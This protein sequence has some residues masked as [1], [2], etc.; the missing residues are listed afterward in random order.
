MQI[1]TT[2]QSAHTTQSHR[3][4]QQSICGTVGIVDGDPDG[5]RSESIPVP[6][7]MTPSEAQILLR[8]W[9]REIAECQRREERGEHPLWLRRQRA[10]AT[11]RLN[12]FCS[13]GLLD[14]DQVRDMCQFY[15]NNATIDLTP[16]ET[17]ASVALQPPSGEFGAVAWSAA[18]AELDWCAPVSDIVWYEGEEPHLNRFEG[19]KFTTG[20]LDDLFVMS[21]VMRSVAN[22]H[23]DLVVRHLE[24]LLAESLIDIVGRASRGPNAYGFYVESLAVKAKDQSLLDDLLFLAE[25]RANRYGCVLQTPRGGAPSHIL[26]PVIRGLAVW[27]GSGSRNRREAVVCMFREMDKLP[28]P[29]WWQDVTDA[30]SADVLAHR[31]WWCE[32][33]IP[34]DLAEAITGHAREVCAAHPPI[35]TVGDAFQW[36]HQHLTCTRD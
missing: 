23:D 16:C 13:R 22:P 7:T 31:L 3:A 11:A 27:V 15:R 36:I 1:Q 4:T 25:R 28:R 21:I 6:A 18:G 8:H 32:S 34:T 26:E 12:E 35:T 24:L 9:T 30:A 14:A 2:N 5:V 17:P 33:V 10:L 20:S 29:K 19:T